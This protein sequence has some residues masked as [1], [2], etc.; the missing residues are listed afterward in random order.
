MVGADVYVE[1]DLEPAELGRS[2]EGV[3]GPDFR[4]E[5]ISARGTVVHPSENAARGHGRLVALPLPSPRR[6]RR[7]GERRRDHRPP[8]ADRRA[9]HSWMHVQKLR[10]FGDEEG[11]TR[12]Q[13]Q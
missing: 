9:A 1:A 8:R 11:Y 13:G 2:L 7:G 12:A 6:G 4:L 3:A 10:M 5:L